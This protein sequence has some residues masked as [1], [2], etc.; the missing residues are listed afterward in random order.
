MQFQGTDL[1]LNHTGL[2]LLDVH[3][4]LQNFRYLTDQKA[5]AIRSKEHGRYFKLP[6]R[7]KEPD[8]DVRNMM[9]LAFVSLECH[10]ALKEWNPTVVG[11]EGYAFGTPKGEMTGEIQGPLKVRLWT[12][13]TPFRIFDVNSVK[14]FA[15]Y[16]GD[17][18]KPAI[19]KAVRERW[20]VDFSRF[21]KPGDAKDV[22]QTEEDLCDAYVV[23]RMCWTEWMLRAGQLDLASLHLKERQV[24]LRC[25]KAQ[26]VN[27]L[28]RSFT[29]RDP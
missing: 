9:R 1:A 5:S 18:K 21:N 15:T 4:E 27:I 25:T 10:R 24:F 14:M 11:I 16:R 13:R 8:N 29:T 3:G 2:C 20:G 17:A 22:R 19:I 23:A 26:P 28:G 12:S 7:K 6:S